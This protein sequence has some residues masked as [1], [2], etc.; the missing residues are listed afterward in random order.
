MQLQQ[1]WLNGWVN[2]SLTLIVVFA[3]FS[4][5][6]QTGSFTFILLED[7]PPLLKRYSP[8]F[9]LFAVPS[10]KSKLSE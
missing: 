2:H 7:I 1:E 10:S 3:S 5:S 8:K 4:F 9:Y 6:L